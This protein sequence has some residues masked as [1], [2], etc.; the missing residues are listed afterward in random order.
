MKRGLGGLPLDRAAAA[1]ACDTAADQ[2]CVEPSLC[3]LTCCFID[4]AAAGTGRR[5]SAGGGMQQRMRLRRCR[6]SSATSSAKL[7]SLTAWLLRH[8][9][10]VRDL[11]MNRL[12]WTQ[13]LVTTATLLTSALT[14]C[15]SAGVLEHL[16]VSLWRTPAGRDVVICT[17]GWA[18][19]LR[20]LRSLTLKCAAARVHLASSLSSLRQLTRLQ[21]HC[22]KLDLGTGV[23]LPTNLEQLSLT[24]YQG[25][26][27][28]Q[29]VWLAGRPAYG[30]A[31]TVRCS[32]AAATCGH[33]AGCVVVCLPSSQGQ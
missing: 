2:R 23:Q 33:I 1:A 15:A 25:V 22:R 14:A 18:P 6:A 20:R 19:A 26:A 5:W 21:L 30:A 8:A 9:R 31:W 4:Y 13:D 32:V 29:Q 28:P 16:A 24:D 7:G 12:N 27:L 17:A 11:H 10:H 3:K